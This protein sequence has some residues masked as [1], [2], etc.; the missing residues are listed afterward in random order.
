MAPSKNR[1]PGFSRRAQFSQFLTYVSAISIGLIG[2]VLLLLANFNPAAL[3]HVRGVASEVTTPISTGLT[4]V[5]G[6]I[7][8]IPT[9]FGSFFQVR[10]ENAALRA[11]IDADDALVAHARALTQENSSLRSLLDL[12]DATADVVVSAR[13][14]RSSPISTR[15]Y[16]T[17]NAGAQQGIEIGQP[18]RE[19]AGLIGRITEASPNTARVLLIIDPESMIPVRRTTDG[20]PAI[21]VGRGDGL[22]DIRSASV[23]TMIFEPGDSFV[24]S[25]TGGIYSPNIP[26]ARVIRTGR[27]LAIAEPAANPDALD[28]AIVQKP[29]LPEAVETATPKAKP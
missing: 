11:K 9:W 19:A 22:L 24:T 8:A 21:A 4:S 6:G 12:H 29:F 20:L 14:V 5:R 25:G 28:F 1:R 26:V 2:A 3:A 23:A 10:K 13:L 17:L 18:V 16:A 27:D 7:A 15:R